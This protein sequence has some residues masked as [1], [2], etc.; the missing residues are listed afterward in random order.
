MRG[1]YGEYIKT[2]DKHHALSIF[3]DYSWLTKVQENGQYGALILKDNEAL[4]I[5][6][7]FSEPTEFNVPVNRT[8]VITLEYN[9][10]TFVLC[11]Y[12]GSIYI[13]IERHYNHYREGGDAPVKISIQDAVF[14]HLFGDEM[15]YDLSYCK[16]YLT[17][18]F[19]Q[20]EKDWEEKMR[21]E[22]EMKQEQQ[23]ES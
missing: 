18:E 21:K 13:G 2:F 20:K 15:E 5:L 11:N 8:N 22:K 9:E 4:S 10:F 14:T 7:G 3:P 12:P 17:D 16:T 19:F 6:A 23:K 1:K